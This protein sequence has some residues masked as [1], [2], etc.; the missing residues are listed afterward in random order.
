MRTGLLPSNGLPTLD[1]GN[2][3]TEVYKAIEHF[4]SN[5]NILYKVNK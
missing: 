5:K 4:L 1:Y 3:E 2:L